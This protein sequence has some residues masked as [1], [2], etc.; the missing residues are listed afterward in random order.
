M[1]PDTLL[2]TFSS[3]ELPGKAII[4]NLRI[5]LFGLGPSTP[6]WLLQ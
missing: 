5:H 1:A 6:F 4:L 3:F 2:E